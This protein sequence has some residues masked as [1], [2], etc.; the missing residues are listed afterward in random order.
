MW[1]LEGSSNSHDFLCS[2]SWTN[3]CDTRHRFVKHFGLKNK[4][5]SITVWLSALR[6]VVI[7]NVALN[8]CMM[9]SWLSLLV[10]HIL[11]F[12]R[13]EMQRHQTHMLANT[14]GASIR[15]FCWNTLFVTVYVSVVAAGC[16]F[17]NTRKLSD[18]KL[19]DSND[20]KQTKVAK[21][22]ANR[23]KQ[24]LCSGESKQCPLHSTC[25]TW[26]AWYWRL[27]NKL[28]L[29]TILHRLIAPKLSS[30]LTRSL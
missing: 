6:Y 27:S 13:A 2:P 19:F 5:G 25:F 23:I 16:V 24:H 1:Q 22:H 17:K 28:L 9:N 7:L 14:S 30:F 10:L 12:S 21:P 18:L 20:G 3:T 8:D 29:A 26:W 15:L 4:G 11:I